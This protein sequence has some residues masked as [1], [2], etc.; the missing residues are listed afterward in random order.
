MANNSQPAG[1]L[2]ALKIPV[3]W[4]VAAFNTSA[5]GCPPVPYLPNRAGGI[6]GLDEQGERVCLR[7]DHLPEDSRGWAG[8]APGWIITALAAAQGALFW[9]DL[10]LKFVNL[11]STGINPDRQKG[12]S[13][14]LDIAVAR[15]ALEIIPHQR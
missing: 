10:L 3:G 12:K 1:R 7:I 14:C 9:F 4:P 15:E 11:R 8:K 2:P 13:V 5:F 6:P